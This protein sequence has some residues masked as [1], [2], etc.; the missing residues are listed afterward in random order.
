MLD[1]HGWELTRSPGLSLQDAC[2]VPSCFA[3]VVL[4]GD[5]LG[6]RVDYAESKFLRL[7]Q[8]STRLLLQ[9]E[10]MGELERMVLLQVRDLRL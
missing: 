4:E 8:S 6:I 1:E 10:A 5:T 9:Q 7:S 2:R 3:T